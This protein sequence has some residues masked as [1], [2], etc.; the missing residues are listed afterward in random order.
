MVLY[1]AAWANS[2]CKALYGVWNGPGRKENESLRTNRF[3][4]RQAIVCHS[5]IR[6]RRTISS[7]WKL[8]EQWGRH[9]NARFDPLKSF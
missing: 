7:D 9:N 3:I 6:G 2:D 1:K 5:K 8:L 4:G